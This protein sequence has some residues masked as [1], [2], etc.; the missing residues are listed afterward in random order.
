M[1]KILMNIAFNLLLLLP[2]VFINIHIR[3]EKADYGFKFVGYMLIAIYILIT[4]MVVKQGG[5]VGI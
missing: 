3:K 4:I 5:L 1:Y 2:I